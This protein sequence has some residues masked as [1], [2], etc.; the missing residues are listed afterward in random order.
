MNRDEHLAWCKKRALEHVGAGDLTNAFSSLVSDMQKHEETRDHPAL[1]L[2]MLL[3]LGGH[4][5]T[6]EEMKIFIEG[7][8]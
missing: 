3:L 6:R 1:G 7:F 2:G 4:L 8:N 5:S